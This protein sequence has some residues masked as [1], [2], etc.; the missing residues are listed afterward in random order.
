MK[1]S[2]SIILISAAIAA[3]ASAAPLVGQSAASV[4]VAIFPTMSNACADCTSKDQSALNIIVK[5]SADHYANIAQGQLDNLMREFEAAKVTN[6]SEDLPSEQKTLTVTVQSTIDEAKQACAPEALAP[7][8]LAIVTADPNLNIPW[9][10]QDLAESKMAALDIA[11]TKMILHR[12]QAILNAQSLSK[13]CTEKI[14]NTEIMPIT[15]VVP[16]PAPVTEIQ[17]PVVPVTT[18][19]VVPEYTAPVPDLAVNVPETPGVAV[20]GTPALVPDTTAPVPV[21]PAVVVPKDPEH[22]PEWTAPAPETP[23][24]VAPEAPPV[25]PETPAVTQEPLNTNDP[26]VKDNN[27]MQDMD[28]TAPVEPKFECT[29]GCKDARDASMVLTLYANMEREFQPRLYQ[30]YNQ[31]MPT[32][33]SESRQDLLSRILANAASIYAV[34]S[35]M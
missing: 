30:F 4:D 15:E 34:L 9:S 21:D 28:V 29:S 14:T 25:A 32:A 16:A 13:D 31:E 3:I 27:I 5:T 20:P 17:K 33:C 1:F 8:I 18:D 11:I 19:P 2:P 7:V 22:V 35:G 26:A 24:A 23:A 12:M 10:K 6:G